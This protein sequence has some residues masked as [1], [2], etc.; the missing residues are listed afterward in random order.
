[1]FFG[2]PYVI[3]IEDASGTVTV[4]TPTIGDIVSIG[5]TMFY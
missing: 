4:Y 5:E 2:E 3:D 1:M